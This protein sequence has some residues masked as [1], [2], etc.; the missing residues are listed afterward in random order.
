M[1]TTYTADQ[2]EENHPHGVERYFWNIARNVIIARSLKQSGMN[3][4]P[5]LGG[6]VILTTRQ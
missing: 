3:G 2:Y 6:G 4:W 1:T 5:L